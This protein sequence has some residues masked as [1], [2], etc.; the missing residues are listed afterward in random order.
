MFPSRT[1]AQRYQV[2]SL[3]SVIYSSNYLWHKH[4]VI[5]VWCT[6]EAMFWRDGGPE[7]CGKGCRDV[8][9][10]GLRVGWVAHTLSLSVNQS[11]TATLGNR[12]CVW[13]HNKQPIRSLNWESS[14]W[15]PTHIHDQSRNLKSV[16]YKTEDKRRFVCTRWDFMYKDMNKAIK[17]WHNPSLRF[18][19]RPKRHRTVVRSANKKC[20]QLICFVEHVRT[21]PLVFFI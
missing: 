7:T 21:I 3:C 12:G 13:C 20:L 4:G 9:S 15:G 14:S 19:L 1:R 6:C 11:I 10:W 8:L 5:Q 18:A 2:R 17:R 16:P